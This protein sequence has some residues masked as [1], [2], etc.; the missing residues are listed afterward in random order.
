[1]VNLFSNRKKDE[2]LKNIRLYQNRFELKYYSLM[3]GAI[4]SYP[5]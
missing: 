1:M 5:P 2:Y 3:L 4:Y